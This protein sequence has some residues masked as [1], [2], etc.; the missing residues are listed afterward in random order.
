[1]KK[2]Y[3]ILSSRFPSF[4]EIQKIALPIISKGD[5]CIVIAPT[6]SGK[7]EAALIPALDIILGSSN[8][9]GISLLYIT[10][11]RAL[12]RDLIKRIE[13]IAKELGI[14]Y[15][16]RHGDTKASERAKQAKSPPQ[17]IITTPESL[18]SMLLSKRIADSF[19][20]LKV[21][22]VDEMHELYSN[23]RGAQLSVALE[24]LVEIN[25]EYQR[26]GISATVGNVDVMK[27]FLC[28]K[29]QCSTASVTLSKEFDISIEMP[30]KPEHAHKELED[31]FGLAP[32]AIARLERIEDIIKASSSVLIFANTRQ[33]VESIGSKLIY[34]NTFEKFGTLAV[35]HSSLN[36][37]ERIRI[38]N[39]FKNGELKAIVATSSL[40][41]GIDIGSIDAVVQYGSPKQAVRLIQRIGRSG[42]KE[43]IK[44][45]GKVIISGLLDALESAVIAQ[46][47][48]E[49]KLENG[50]AEKMALDVMINQISAIVLQYRSVEISTVKKIFRR[51]CIFQDMDDEVFEKVLKF[52]EEL[53]LYRTNKET[54]NMGSRTMRYF[55][56]N[57]SLIPD[58]NT[59]MLKYAADNK[60]ISTLDEGFVS[61]YIDEGSV[62]ITKGLPWKVVSIEEDVIYVEPSLDIQAAVPD[63]EGEDIPVSRSVAEGVFSIIRNKRIEQKLMKIDRNSIESFEHFLKLQV[64]Y[65]FPKEEVL[66]VEVLEDYAVIHSPLGKLGN[67]FFARMLVKS[68]YSYTGK[69]YSARAS[70]YAIIIEFASS[71]RL[72]IKKALMRFT[73]YDAKKFAS[74]P[75][76]IKS[77]E[78]FRFKFIQIAKRFGILDKKAKVTKS[79][80][81][82]LIEFYKDSPIFKETTR[83][84]NKNYFDIAAVDE[85]QKKIKANV[86]KVIVNDSDCSPLAHEMLKYAYY[87]SELIGDVKENGEEIRRFTDNVLNKKVNFLCTFCGIEFSETISE[88]GSNEKIRCVSCKSPMVTI[89]KEGYAE[90]IKLK[91]EGKKLKQKEQADYIN[92]IKVASLI[93]A[94]GARAIIALSTYGV[95]ADTAA[96]ILKMLRK[97]DRLFLADLINAQKNFIKNRKYW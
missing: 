84:I 70:P 44:A 38:E 67:E 35:H 25:G 52:G 54:L 68:I 45:N 74:D 37:D 5:N 47:A 57:I 3:G 94:Y 96:R 24:R 78:L 30:K 97:D 90:I 12:N 2:A 85:L 39:M 19:I 10:P 66:N 60:L 91:K 28:G 83:D 7:T 76:F 63:W 48:I 65:G 32:D 50:A 41:L 77:T 89:D 71:N 14:S 53:H 62:F 16:V 80:T 11:L 9:E 18:Q 42:H 4:T 81:D 92:M 88:I 49:G 17:L 82:R 46:H 15:G 86:M 59:F 64:D 26:I 93:E 95:G 6:G 34:M 40:E 55:F 56:G 31:S 43:G 69:R 79:M 87:Y 72:D 8:S 73:E 51:S 61:N 36:R 20:N 27:E 29:R 33:V 1:L 75:D 13:V 23:K 58:K 22:I 21:V